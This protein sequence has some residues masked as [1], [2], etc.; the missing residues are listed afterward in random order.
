VSDRDPDALLA[1]LDEARDLGFLGPGPVT[2]QHQHALYLARAIGECRGRVLDLGSG[3]GLPGLVLFEQWPGASG[4]LL[5]AQRRRCEFLARAVVALELADR[6]AVTCGRAE[7]L[8]RDPALRGQ[9]DL[10]TARAFG[11]PAVTAECAV[12]FLR[13]GG[14]LVVTE[15]PEPAGPE[16]EGILRWDRDGLAALGFGES[17]AIR[18]GE[19][20]AMRLRL[21]RLAGE[22]WPRRDGVPA[23]RPLW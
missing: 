16:A 7:L 9:F 10:V 4:V 22:K 19:T 18:A 12:G 17:A 2:R 13:A 3:G 11:P 6:V 1:L 15:P 20:G 8:A 14:E 21:S 23:K 5:D